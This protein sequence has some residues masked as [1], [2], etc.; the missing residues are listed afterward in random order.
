LTET[1]RLTYNTRSGL[2]TRKSAS[3]ENLRNR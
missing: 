2:L 3:L 1:D